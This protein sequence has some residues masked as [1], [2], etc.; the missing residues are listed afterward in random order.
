MHSLYV[1]SISN[2][3]HYEWWWVSSIFSTWALSDQDF[4]ELSFSVQPFLTLC[5][6]S[7]GSTRA[8]HRWSNR[9]LTIIPNDF[10]AINQNITLHH[11]LFPSNE[12]YTFKHSILSYFRQN[13][14]NAGDEHLLPHILLFHQY[15][16]FVLLAF[17][18]HHKDET[19]VWESSLVICTTWVWQRNQ[20]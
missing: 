17:Y 6:E 10:S 20:K 9:R 3:E 2:N 15:N 8:E 4:L 19:Q 11:L 7:V 1:K 5:W 12:I 13:C 18:S 14:M 16:L